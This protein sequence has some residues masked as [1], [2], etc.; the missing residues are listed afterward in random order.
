M[1]IRHA[2][3]NEAREWLAQHCPNPTG[4]DTWEHRRARWG[5]F[6]LEKVMRE[7][8]KSGRWTVN[9]ALEWLLSQD[10]INASALA[11]LNRRT[12]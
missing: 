2:G 8:V 6:K 10:Y 1:P 12:K 7:K 3:E 5:A 4:L 9:Q 11:W